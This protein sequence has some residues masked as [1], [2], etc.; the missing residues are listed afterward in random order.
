MQTAWSNHSTAN[1]GPSN[2]TTLHDF[3]TRASSNVKKLRANTIFWNLDKIHDFVWSFWQK[4]PKSLREWHHSTI[5]QPDDAKNR[6]AKT[7]KNIKIQLP[8][9]TVTRF[10]MCPFE[11][12]TFWIDSITQI[13]RSSLEFTNFH[14][15]HVS[16]R[17]QYDFR[18]A[19]TGFWDTLNNSDDESTKASYETMRHRAE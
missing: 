3:D 17:R 9:S 14:E 2:L 7:W 13:Y 16:L 15:I 19:T 10:G 8:S 4:H 18:S 6:F 12:F 1:P 5:R 11:G